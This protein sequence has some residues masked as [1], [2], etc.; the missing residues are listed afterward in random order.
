MVCICNKGMSSARHLF[1]LL[2]DIKVLCHRHDVFFHCF[3]ISG[4][5]MIATGLDGFSRGVKESGIALGYDLRDFLPLATSAFDV[6][7]NG[8]ENWCK[9]WMGNDYSPPEGP[10][11]WFRDSHQPGV[12]VIVPPPAAALAAL[13][14]VAKARHK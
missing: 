8:L 12:H 14:E 3:H 1:D 11:A 6:K 4:E 9:Y 10:L 5:R 13:K 2:V 7:D